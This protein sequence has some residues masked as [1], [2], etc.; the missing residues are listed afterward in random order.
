MASMFAFAMPQCFCIKRRLLLRRQLGV[1]SL[2]G[3]TTLAHGGIPLGVHGLHTVNALRGAELREC[4]AIHTL[5]PIASRVR[6][7]L[8]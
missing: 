1:K 4:I 3:F 6:R 7:R 8:H 5:L 2:D